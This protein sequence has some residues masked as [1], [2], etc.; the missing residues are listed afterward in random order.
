MVAHPRVKLEAA[1]VSICTCD[2]SATA[3]KTSARSEYILVVL[4]FLHKLL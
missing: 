4:T 2:V 1:I 3:W